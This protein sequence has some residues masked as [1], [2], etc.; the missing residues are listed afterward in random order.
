MKSENE[1]RVQVMASLRELS[2]GRTSLF[3]AHRL[4]TV[5][6]CDRILVMSQGRVVEEGAHDSLVELGGLYASMWRQQMEGKPVADSASNGE[7][8]TS[9][10]VDSGRGAIFS[11]SSSA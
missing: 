11:A 10:T 3:V 6:H 1:Q 4:G 5:R 7:G 8:Q 2:Q 9:G